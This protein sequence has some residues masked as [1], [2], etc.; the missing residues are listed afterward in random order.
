MGS[1]P[2]GVSKMGFSYPEFRKIPS[3]YSLPIAPSTRQNWHAPKLQTKPVHLCENQ[4]PESD[5]GCSFSLR[6]LFSIVKT[7]D[8]YAKG[9]QGLLA[10]GQ[11][12]PVV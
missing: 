5:I 3:R 10:R 7:L 8:Y 4:R 9:W 12:Q 6:T 2:S 1:Q 11:A